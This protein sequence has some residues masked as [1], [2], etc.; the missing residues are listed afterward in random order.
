MSSNSAIEQ[1]LILSKQAKDK[2]LETIISQVL[3]DPKIYV[4]GEFLSLPQ[5]QALGPQNK[6]L[7]TL[8]LFAYETF[9]EYTKA[10]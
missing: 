3:N 2:A 5:V 7:R 9:K 4:F 6:Y 1:Y 10:P 8:N